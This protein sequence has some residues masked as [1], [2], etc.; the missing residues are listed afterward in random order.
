MTSNDTPDEPD[1]KAVR[2]TAQAAADAV[3]ARN[4]AIC[5]ARDAGA[6]LRAIADATDGR[7]THAA[8]HKIATRK[9]E[10]PSP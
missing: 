4:A 9:R 10:S 5:A 3:A 6:T 7:L 2:R 1:L 8:V